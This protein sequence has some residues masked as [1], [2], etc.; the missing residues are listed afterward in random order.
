MRRSNEGGVAAVEFALIL[1][2]LVVFLF[3]I[4]EFGLAFTK[5]IAYAAGAR[6]GARYA[7]VHC[8]P[9]ASSCTDGLI[10]DRIE[11]S[12]PDYPLTFTAF[13]AAP[14]CAASPGTGLVTVTW[15]ETVPVEIPLL[16]DLS[17]TFEPTGVFRCE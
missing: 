9:D 11:A 16:G 1:P 14:N 5:T 4:V 8:E 13:S 10:Q 2:L 12:I 17:W 7:A 3:A 6:E 15:Q